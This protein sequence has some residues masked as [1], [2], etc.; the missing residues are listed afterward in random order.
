M[1]YSVNGEEGTQLLDRAAMESIASI[2]ADAEIVFGVAESLKSVN[3]AVIADGDTVSLGDIVVI[4][5]K[6]TL[7]GEAFGGGSYEKYT[8]QLGYASFVEG[9]EEAI[10]GHKVGETFTIDVKFPEN[11]STTSLAGKDTKFEITRMLCAFSIIP[12][13][14]AP[15]CSAQNAR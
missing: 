14:S 15:I 2:Y 10:V 7:N 8:M 9:F 6:G 13:M 1:S 4:D 3:G 12:C 5:Y 11:Y